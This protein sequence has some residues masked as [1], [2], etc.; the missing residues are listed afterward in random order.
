MAR[1]WKITS[2]RGRTALRVSGAAGQRHRIGEE[3]EPRYDRFR[4]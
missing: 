2:A 3:A 4:V 1:T